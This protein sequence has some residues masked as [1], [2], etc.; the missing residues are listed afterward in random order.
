MD[1]NISIT[2]LGEQ[3]LFLQPLDIVQKQFILIRSSED[4]EQPYLCVELNS[5]N[6]FDVLS[7]RDIAEPDDSL[8]D[9]L[10][11]LAIDVVEALQQGVDLSAITL[12]ESNT[13]KPYNSDKIRVETKT[14]SLRQ[15]YDMIK[16][17]DIDLSPAFQRNI[18]WNTFRKSRLVESILLRI[19]LPMFYF[20]Q[21]DEGKLQVVDGLQR[22]SAIKDFMDNKLVLKN[23]E[24]LT[25][26]ENCTYSNSNSKIEDKLYRRFNMTQI[27]ANIIDPQSPVKVKYDIFRR[28]NTGG[29]PLNSQE[30]R[31]CLASD[32]FRNLLKSMANLESFK[33]VSGG[34]ISDV[35]M[36][37]QE[38]ALRFILFKD[39]YSNGIESYSGNMEDEL[40]NC[41]EKYSRYTADEISH[42]LS[43]YDIA[44]KNAYYLF[45]KHA[46]R[47]IDSRTSD[48]S[49]RSILNKALFVSW[50]VILSQYQT[51]FIKATLQPKA[52]LASLGN[53]I[54]S[55][56]DYFNALTYGTNG[57]KNIVVAFGKAEE[58]L[59]SVLPCESL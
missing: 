16:D 3:R 22:L 31:N 37:A 43:S 54:S 13:E 12:S 57:W 5:N 49:P 17:G 47:K 58:I 52:L 8:K 9:K 53:E 7:K 23:L 35:R 25:S 19:P 28:L 1:L 55:D 51:D 56:I 18:V 30:L 50:S 40:D 44:L 36:E 48:E 46:F 41:V 26:C 21:D 2:D 38:L 11:Q 42:F 14:F 15:V 33:D 39:L 34:R 20:S 4:V 29:K 10:N 32:N 24:Y 59:K 6:T 27:T 45:G